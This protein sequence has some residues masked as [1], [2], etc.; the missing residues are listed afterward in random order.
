MVAL[1]L[2]TLHI[3][4][5]LNPLLISGC[6]NVV[7]TDQASFGIMEHCFLNIIL[8]FS[9]ATDRSMIQCM[10][11]V[12]LSQQISRSYTKHNRLWYMCY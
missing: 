3:H 7:V 6:Y 2:Y 11:T 12:N 4:S 5:V 9:S 8:L 1:I 10:G